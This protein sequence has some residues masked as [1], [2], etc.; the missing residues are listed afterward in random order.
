MR[1]F[2]GTP[3]D[4]PL[5]CQRCGELDEQCTCEPEQRQW[6]KPEKQVAS[7]SIEKR[8]RGK[9]VTIVRGLS[10]AENDLPALLSKLKTICGAGGSLKVDL[11]EVQ[12]NHLDRVKEELQKIGYRISKR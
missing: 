8:K 9:L 3:F 4:R 1:L 11:L 12:G 7:V 5:R 6:T 2:E 10:A